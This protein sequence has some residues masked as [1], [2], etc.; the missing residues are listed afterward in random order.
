MK[1]RS[2]GGTRVLVVSKNSTKTD[3]FVT[4][5]RTVFFQVLS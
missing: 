3:I 4:C 1:N 5:Q 2:S